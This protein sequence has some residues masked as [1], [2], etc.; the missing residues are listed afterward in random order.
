MKRTRIT[1]RTFLHASAT[2][3]GCVAAT[4]FTPNPG[5]A[6]TLGWNLQDS[7]P[8]V[9][10]LL[11]RYVVQSQPATIPE[12]V[13]RQAARTLL[14]WI[15]CA[16]GGSNH[17]T[18]DCALAALTEFSGPRL[19]TVLGRK[20]RLDAP[21]A[22]LINGISSHVLDF[23]DTQ[24]KTIIHPAGPVLPAILALAERHPVTGVD[25][26]H[27]FILGVEVECRIGKAVYPAHYDAGYHITGTAGIFGAAAASG[28]LLGLSEQQ[29]IWALG[30]AAT[31]AAGLR[32]MFGS[33]CKSLHVGRAAQN[34]L[35]A[36]LLAARNFT[37]SDRGIE[38][39]R[40]FAYIL[41]PA[42]NF[43]AISE[44]LGTNYEILENTFKP[45]ACGI[46]IHPVID[47][48]IQLR[49]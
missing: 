18:V 1:R 34:G 14:N 7:G 48:C 42:R 36:A 38:A 12:P 22:A 24:L 13:V 49:N 30:T 35:E 5:P 25:F 20:E 2:A 44:G 10:R 47:G 27:A 26:L 21:H 43:A 39:A 45:F 6:R 28:K 46:V 41:S 3:G 4:G 16:V 17:E 32:E 11:A 8:S 40:G 33:M 15:G 31:Q 37:S 29:M 19:A 23:D 9:T